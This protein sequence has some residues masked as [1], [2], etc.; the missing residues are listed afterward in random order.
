MP[1]ENKYVLITE[2]LTFGPWFIGWRR[3]TAYS[4][5]TTW[6]STT[7]R[8]PSGRSACW[9]PRQRET[10]SSGSPRWYS[11]ETSE[12]APAQDSLQ[13]ATPGHA[14]RPRPRPPHSHSR[15]L[16]QA[17]V[18]P[19]GVREHGSVGWGGPPASVLVVIRESRRASVSP[20][21]KRLKRNAEVFLNWR[22]RGSLDTSPLPRPEN[23]RSDTCINVWDSVQIM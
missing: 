11:P 13:A 20:N 8:R 5:P 19:W 3:V 2:S 6:R 12:A 15:R 14:A 4:R 17:R 1:Q 23:H 22:F 16:R 9:G 7:V 21:S 18:G 10:P